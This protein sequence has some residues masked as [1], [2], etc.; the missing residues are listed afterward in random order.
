MRSGLIR[1]TRRLLGATGAAAMAVAGVLTVGL[2]PLDRAAAIDVKLTMDE[3][4]KALAAGRE[5]MLAA[6]TVEGEDEQRK[7]IAKALSL[8][9]E[10]YV[11]TPNPS[12]DPCTRVLF[13]TKRFTLEEY[14]RT[15][16]KES[17]KEGKEIRMP[18]KFIQKVIDMPIMQIEVHLCGDKEYF[19]E[20]VE[21][22]L[23]QQSGYIKPLDTGRA[24]RGR[25]NEGQ[26][27]EYRS[28]FTARFSY[29]A[30]DPVAPTKVVV[31]FPD[32][33]LKEIPADLSEI[34]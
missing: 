32:G 19:A 34:R 25:K 7:Q 14:G 11:V 31:V 29:D 8:A 21:V 6:Y 16:A 18:E 15:E 10:G 17:V 30:F 5:P 9:T 33:R 24:Q 13:G 1:V 4:K 22:V 12:E 3:A 28:R 23:Q 27:A 2:G 20:G 26:G